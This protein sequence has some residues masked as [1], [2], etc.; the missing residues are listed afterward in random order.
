MSDASPKRVW[1]PNGPE[2]RLSIAFFRFLKDCL[3]H[4]CY[5][6]AN[7]DADRGTRSQLQ[8]A[9]DANKGIRSGQLDFEVEQG[10]P[11]LFRRVELKRGRNTATQLQELTLDELR[12]CGANPIVAWTLQTA[13]EQLSAV[14][15]RFTANAAT[16]LQ[17]YE[18]QLAAWDREAELKKAGAA[19]RKRAARTKP[20]P[21]FVANARMAKTMNG[22]R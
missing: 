11:H 9:R 16:K 2:D 13:Y 20:G 19:P 22:G 17:F 10:P 8:R 3:E 18:E 4:P 15:F 6:T 21:R 5:F 1:V 14:G 7:H 12:A